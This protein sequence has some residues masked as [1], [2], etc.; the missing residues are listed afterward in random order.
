[1]GNIPYCG[2][3]RR[4]CYSAKNYQ[5]LNKESAGGMLF[6][7]EYR[8]L[9]MNPLEEWLFAGNYHLLDEAPTGGIVFPPESLNT[10]FRS[11]HVFTFATKSSW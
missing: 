4:N 7:Q 1:V 9:L 6:R 8:P 11:E 10:L 3:T 2:I 5:L